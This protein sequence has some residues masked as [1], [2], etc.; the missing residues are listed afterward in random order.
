M[1]GEMWHGDFTM[2]YIED[3]TQ[4]AGQFKKFNVF[5]KMLVSAI[6]NH[7]GDQNAPNNNQMV[8][9]N[10]LSQSDLM[11]LKHQQMG[12]SPSQNTGQNDK[13]EKK[14]IILTFQGEFEKVH[15]PLPL[16][17]LDEPDMDQMF[18]TFQ[19]LQNYLQMSRTNTFTQ[20]QNSV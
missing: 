6:K 9:I 8:S 16:K 1:S 13:T 12:Q 10:L 3:I 7:S 2:K 14:Y 18:K 4:K 17:Y 15:Y 20:R 5:A 19:R 11:Q